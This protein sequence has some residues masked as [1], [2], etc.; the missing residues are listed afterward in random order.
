VSGNVRFA[1]SVPPAVLDWGDA[2]LG[3]PAFDILTLSE[4]LADD[5]AQALV[6]HWAALWRRAAPGSEPERAAELLRPVGPLLGA[7]VYA[8][9]VHNIEPSEWPYHSEDVP[10]C[11]RTAVSRG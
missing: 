5:E 9:F 2:F 7:V 4:G 1:D 10:T 11:L 8:A 3:H 6:A